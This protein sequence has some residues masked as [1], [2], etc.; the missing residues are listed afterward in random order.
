MKKNSN[1]RAYV[2]LIFIL[3]LWAAIISRL[4][5]LQ[6]LKHK[7]YQAQALGQQITFNSES[8]PR[9]RIFCEN[10][11]QTKGQNLSGEIKSLAINK[12]S[13]TISAN[14]KKI[15]DKLFFAES[16]GKLIGLAKEK[17]IESLAS[18]NSYIV[19]KKGITPE[20]LDK[21]KR[22]GLDGIS[23]QE[24]S[25]RFYPQEGMASQ[26]IG[27]LGGEGLGQYGIEGHYDDILKGKTGMQQEKIGIDSIFSKNSEISLDGSDLYLTIDYNIQFQAEN[28]L[29]KTK[30]KLDISSGQIIVMR[31]DT[32]RILAL[33]NYPSFN[34]NQYSQESDL[35]I[36]Q[37]TITQ[38]LFEPGSIM[39]PFTM[40][41]AL[42]EGK[43][44]P[45]TTYVDTGFV[46]FGSKT[47]HNFAN[48]V[49]GTKTMTEVLE[50]S[51]NTG[52]VFASQQISH[53]T[54]LDYMD[55]FGFGGKT[56]I[57]LQGEV[58]SSN[59]TLRNN[60][61]EMNF[62]TASFG[63]GIELTPLQIARGFCAIA[64]GG[65][66]VRPY[67]VEKIISGGD[68]QKINPEISSP[69]ISQQTASQLTSMLVN[70]V[71]KGFNGVAKIPGYYMAGKTGTA[72]I[73]LKNGRGYESDDKTIQSFV[74]FGPAY[75]P[76]FLIMVKLDS[77]KVSKSSL[78][79]VPVFKELAQYI[80]N[81]WQIP[82]DYDVTTNPVK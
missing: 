52:A 44:T 16:L 74:G 41:A 21:I 29:K 2:V 65:R 35:E 37:N 75:N 33:A 80:I 13:W 1:W 4:F 12:T 42:N 57:D 46:K 82:P 59:S 60:G 38:K 81:Y 10:S 20:E 45:D 40:A 22:L 6:V 67:I 34:P 30:E 64:N 18:Q 26:V 58:Y 24:N 78:S 49:Y 76:Q 31:P 66:L 53:K 23:W 5:F 61:P 39:K 50:N 25:Q 11:Q 48:E 72:Q 19:I 77:P 14:P 3:I 36:F 43:I 56:G 73:P 68:E 69:I 17:I 79:A 7:F 62:A 28:L 55:K 8:G 47:I 63:Q 27:F 32:G 71:D 51:I 15:T 9:G 54:F 70:V